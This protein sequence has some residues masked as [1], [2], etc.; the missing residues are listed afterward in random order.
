LADDRPLEVLAEGKY[1]RFLSEGGWEYV[2][3]PHSTGVVVIVAITPARELILVE[4]HRV[5]VHASVVE[6]PAG[7]VGDTSALRGETLETA[8][9]RE[10]IEETGFQAE[11]MVE[12]GSGPISVGVSSEVVTFFHAQNLRRVGPGGGDDTEDIAVHVVPLPDLR[13][14]LAERQRAGRLVDPKIFSG[15]YLAGAGGG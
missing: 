2:M 7:L 9:Y 15:L 8:A 12:L 10:L 4:Q 3:R 1:L 13:A 5:S 11:K 6:L 14:F